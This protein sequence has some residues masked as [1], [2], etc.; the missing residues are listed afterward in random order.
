MNR[1]RVLAAGARGSR[2]GVTAS[3]GVCALLLSVA[4]PSLLS[5]LGSLSGPVGCH[6]SVDY[7]DDV[8][9]DFPCDVSDDPSGGFLAGFVGDAMDD[10]SDD[11]PDDL[12]DD[13]SDDFSD[14]PCVLE[15]SGGADGGEEVTGEVDPSVV[16]AGVVEATPAFTG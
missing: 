9:D 15:D 4:V 13:V 16:D 6:S 3:V 14:P 11:V 5:A 12:S 1:F 10:L 2:A 8:T 7:S